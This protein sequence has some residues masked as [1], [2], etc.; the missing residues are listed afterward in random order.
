L[1]SRR[2][3]FSTPP[4]FIMIKNLKDLKE[5]AFDF[6]VKAGYTAAFILLLI[7][8]ILTL[9]SNTQLMKQTEWV[10]H[11]NIVMKNLE[12]LVSGVKD[13]ETGTRGYINSKDTIFLAPYKNSFAVVD[14][15]Y[16]AL[17]RDTRENPFQ[18]KYLSSIILLIKERYEK[19]AFAIDYFPKNN[20]VIT[21]TLLQSF[22]A[23][24][25]KMDMIRS[26]VNAMQ[27]HEENLLVSRTNELN[28]KYK[29]LNTIVIT[30]IVLALVFAL[31]GYYTYKRENNARLAADKKVD[32]YQKELQHRIMELD[33]ANKE[34][35]LMKRSEKFAATGRIARTIAHEVRNPL[36]NI[37]LAV[38]QIKSDMP[39]EDDSNNMLFDMVERNSKRINQLIS[40]LLSATRFAEL[41]YVS[42]SIND[43]LDEALDMA[44]DR[45]EL[46]KIKVEKKYSHDI[47]NI[48]VDSEKVKIAFLNLI[49]NAIEAMEPNNG[50]LL[51]ETKGE[52]EKCVVEISDNGHGIPEGELNNLFE[53]YFT[54]KPNGNGLGLTNT[55]N[56][57]LNHKGSIFVTS[58]S[59]HGTTFVIKFDFTIP[60]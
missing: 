14:T 51:I 21:D 47:C 10:N 60:V 27:K 16:N 25:A 13:A 12:S 32:D 15:A 56:I 20:Y 17:E 57:I 4:L 19:L 31:F 48:S 54:T 3:L 53:P 9:Y 8:Y 28:I 44:K 37:G 7:S 46:N 45:I 49:V 41:S 42:V 50:I 58:K 23:G 29:T 24:K 43:L 11:T 38:A 30:S 34:L 35:V 22:Y 59:G 1:F 26:T 52:R 55:H 18:K 36:T 2:V 40:E 33:T 5:K 6:R 39:A